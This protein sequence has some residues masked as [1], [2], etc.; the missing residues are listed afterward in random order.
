M[1]NRKILNLRILRREWACGVVA[2]LLHP[3]L[4]LCRCL[5]CPNFMFRCS[6]A[7][8]IMATITTTTTTAAVDNLLPPSA[9][10]ASGLLAR[11]HLLRVEADFVTC[12]Q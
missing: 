7:R 4:G 9:T 8:L 11:P 10:A 12:T 3:H 6:S 5:A 1:K 2:L